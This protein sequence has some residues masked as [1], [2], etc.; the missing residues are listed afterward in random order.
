[1]TPNEIGQIL[2]E[3]GG[4][5]AIIHEIREDVKEAKDE[6]KTTNG[7]VTSIEKRH[8]AEDTL[9]MEHDRVDALRVA[10][11]QRWGGWFMPIVSGSIAGIIVTVAAKLL[12]GTP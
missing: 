5:K 1:M 11:K 8:E 10:T 6:I 9:R 7:R 2:K 4:I 3:L 12:T